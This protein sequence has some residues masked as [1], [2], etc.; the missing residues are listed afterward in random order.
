MLQRFVVLLA[1]TASSHATSSPLQLTGTT[2]LL[3]GNPYW[4]DPN[5]VGKIPRDIALKTFG[6]NTSLLGGFRP[7]SVVDSATG[8]GATTE[9][10]EQ[11]LTRFLAED[12]VWSKDFS[13]SEYRLL[14]R[15]WS[16]LTAG[17][18]IAK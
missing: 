7:I 3:G 4:V 6:N 18:E 9:S 1:L 12:D 11:S 15:M 17:Q 8:S 13:D 5:A 2:A 16:Y 10:L 14:V